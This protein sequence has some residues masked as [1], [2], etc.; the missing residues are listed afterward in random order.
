MRPVNTTAACRVCGCLIAEKIKGKLKKRCSICEIVSNLVILELEKISRKRIIATMKSS[1][2]L[3]RQC[4]RCG[5]DISG[6]TGCSFCASCRSKRRDAR[7]A[8]R[9]RDEANAR[10]KFLN[11]KKLNFV[12]KMYQAS[13]AS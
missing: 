11:S 3:K 1:R 9:S 10:Y 13:A 5:G 6:D 8:K 12:L 2:R 4:L 7:V